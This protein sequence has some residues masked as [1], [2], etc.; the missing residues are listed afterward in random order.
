[1][2]EKQNFYDLLGVKRDAS[3][4]ELRAA[5]RKLAR[6]YHPDVNPGDKTA[7][8][9][10][11]EINAAYE[12][13]S[14]PEKRKKYDKYGERWE[15]ADQIEEQR[16]QRASAGDW[17]R[18][19]QGARRGGAGTG[20][21]GGF[22]MP[23]ID[24]GGDLGDIFGNVFRSRPT[25]RKGEDLEYPLEVTLE[26]AYSGTTRTLT[27]ES[28][29]PCPGCHG[30][31][32]AGDAICQVCDGA[33]TLGKPR[34]LEVKIPAGVKTGSRV[35]IAGEG[36]PGIGGGPKGDLYLKISVLPNDHFERKGDDLFEEVPVPLYDAVLGGEV[37]V[38]TMTGRVMLKV[39]AGSQNGASI[40]LSGK[41]MPKLGAS[42]HGDLYVKL[43]V[44]LPAPLNERERELFQELRRLRE[45]QAAAAH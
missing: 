20:S 21:T 37:A 23:N 27:I 9:K 29:E 16:R 18:T 19:A 2:A 12:V 11:K 41:G 8:A 6:R 40:R 24:L 4:K 44:V 45:P 13:L 32:L 25:T 17:F 28:N 35:R 39:P 1:M 31:G 15:L 7:E 36:Q 10:F 38:P 43:K 14:D 5:Y 26:Q 30:T 22:R 34:R 42:G 3:E 33:G